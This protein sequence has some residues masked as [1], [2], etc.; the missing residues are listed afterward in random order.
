VLIEEDLRR[1]SEPVL[2]FTDEGGMARPVNVETDELEPGEAGLDN[3]GSEP[4][5]DDE[6]YEQT[7]E[8]ER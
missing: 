3:E 2:I 7:D 6:N 1:G 4:G 5:L 8:S